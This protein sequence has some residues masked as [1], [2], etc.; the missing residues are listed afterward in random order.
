MR[1][2]S[3]PGFLN[4]DLDIDSASIVPNDPEQAVEAEGSGRPEV[5]TRFDRVV[6]GGAVPPPVTCR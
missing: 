2:K 3:P 1:P 6:V 5:G 4:V